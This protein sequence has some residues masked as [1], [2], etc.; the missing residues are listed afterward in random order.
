MSLSRGGGGGGRAFFFLFQFHFAAQSRKIIK[1]GNKS[2]ARQMVVRLY[3]FG[4]RRLQNPEFYLQAC[5]GAV[6]NKNI[7]ALQT[8]QGGDKISKRDL[9]V[10]MQ[11]RCSLSRRDKKC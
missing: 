6:K 5:Y 10:K 2:T 9:G 1:K 4:W 11:L 7:S 8:D 3:T